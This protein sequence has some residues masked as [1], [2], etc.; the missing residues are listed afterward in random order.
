MI[1][2][3]RSSIN[4]LYDPQP[5]LNNLVS[6]LISHDSFQTDLSSFKLT[7]LQILPIIV[8]REKMNRESGQILASLA[9][10]D[11]VH[12]KMYIF[13]LSCIP[14]FTISDNTDTLK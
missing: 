5:Y 12:K 6:V 1:Y 9:T 2:D 13:S 4:S 8:G 3:T 7:R 11:K 14:S 10:M